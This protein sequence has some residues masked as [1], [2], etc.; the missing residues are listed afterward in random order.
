V[1]TVGAVIDENHNRF[2]GE[3][4]GA[5][6]FLEAIDDSAVAQSLLSTAERWTRERGMTVMRGPLNF[7]LNQEIGTLVDGFDSP[8]MVMMTYNPRYYPPLIEGQ[9]YSKAMDVF[10]WIADIKSGLEVAPAKLFRVAEKAAQR[11]GIRVRKIDLRHFDRDIALFKQVYNSA[12]ERNWGFVPMTDAEID[13][14]AKGLR[15]VLDPD[16]VLIAQLD[17]GTPVGVSLTVPDIH[18]A[19]RWSGGGRSWP[20]G[21]PKFLWHKR[22]V[23]QARLMTM[24]MVEQY[25]GRGADALFYLETAKNALARGYRRLEGS[26]ILETNNMM[27]Q[28]LERLGMTHYKTYRIYEKPL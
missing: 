10:A 21:L 15:P 7:S 22:R 11:E 27:N 20:F 14:L 1:G 3:K 5:F 6:G 23:D 8:P 25:R 9:G 12:W 17:D 4:A 2:H 19:L 16:L 13:H 24:G 28:I 18:Q 26:W